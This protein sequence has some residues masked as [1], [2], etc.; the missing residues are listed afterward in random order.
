MNSTKQQDKTISDPDE[1]SQQQ[2]AISHN[3]R[4]DMAEKCWK[5]EKK[6]AEITTKDT[7]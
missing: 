5:L 1:G 3:T 2:S 6:Q 7:H 4:S